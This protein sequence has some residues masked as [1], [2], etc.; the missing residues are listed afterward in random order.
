MF[1]TK[2]VKKIKTHILYSITFSKNRAVYEIMWKNMVEKGRKWQY[3]TA[4][5][6]CVLDN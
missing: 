5:A 4:H 6:L 2:A 1:Q 3:N